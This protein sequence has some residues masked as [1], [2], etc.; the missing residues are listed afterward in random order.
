MLLVVHGEFVTRIVT[1]EWF[2]GFCTIKYVANVCMGINK[3]RLIII[4]SI[5]V[6]ISDRLMDGWLQL[7][8]AHDKSAA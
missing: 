2:N 4:S 1:L 5:G 6:I 3:V 8:K 7:K